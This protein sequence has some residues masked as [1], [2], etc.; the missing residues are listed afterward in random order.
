MNTVW[1][2]ILTASAINHIAMPAGGEIISCGLDG[3]K[4]LCVWAEVD[5]SEEAKDQKLIAVGTGMILP[6]EADDEIRQFIGSVTMPDG[7]VWHI[8]WYEH[9]DEEE[10]EDF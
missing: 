4:N 7:L 6:D 8:Y 2:Y 5:S 9:F 3:D 1:K 10:D